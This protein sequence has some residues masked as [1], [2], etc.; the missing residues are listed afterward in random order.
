LRGKGIFFSLNSGSHF[1]AV[2]KIL[3]FA[4]LIC[5]FL[6][7]LLYFYLDFSVDVEYLQTR[8]IGLAFFHSYDKP[9][10]EAFKW[11]PGKWISL[12]AEK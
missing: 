2:C 5:L 7:T 11:I 10:Y 3:T 4:L 9:T 1:Q 12:P 6:L 8:I